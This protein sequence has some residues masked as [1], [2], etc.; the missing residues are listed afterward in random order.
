MII[1]RNKRIY[2]FIV[3]MAVMMLCLTTYSEN[4]IMAKS[5]DDELVI[6]LKRL[7]IHGIMNYPI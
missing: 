3:I 6:K 2:I 4:I 5:K 1:I 7:F